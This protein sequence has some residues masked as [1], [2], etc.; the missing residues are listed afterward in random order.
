MMSE[1]RGQGGKHDSDGGEPPSFDLSQ[2]SEMMGESSA[3]SLEEYQTYAEAESV[4]DFYYS[5]SASANGS[6][7]FEAVTSEAESSEDEAT[8]TS[9]SKDNSGFGGR[10]YR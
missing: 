1:M 4:K 3:L 2:F 8:D 5:L 7:N 10:T 9:T 6:D